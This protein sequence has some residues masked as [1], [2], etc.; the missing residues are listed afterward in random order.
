KSERERENGRTGEGRS[1]A[2]SAQ[3]VS[4]V[5]RKALHRAPSP[6]LRSGLLDGSAIAKLAAS[7]KLRVIHRLFVH[8]AGAQIDVKL[9]LFSQVVGKLVAAE[10]VLRATPDFA[11]GHRSS[12]KRAAKSARWLATRV[13]SARVRSPVAS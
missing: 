12:A 2:E 1:L 4:Q 11:N 9:H 13:R 6:V 7:G 5:L 10:Q 8:L 3:G